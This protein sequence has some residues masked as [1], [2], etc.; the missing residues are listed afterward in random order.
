MTCQVALLDGI[1][2]ASAIFLLVI[3]LIFEASGFGTFIAGQPGALLLVVI[4]ISMFWA[5]WSISG[6]RSF[7]CAT[8]SALNMFD[9]ASTL[10][11][12]NFEINPAVR[13]IGP[14]LFLVSKISCSIVIVLYAKFHHAPKRGG[15]ILSLLLA[16]IVGW[17]LSQHTLA[18]LGLSNV[19][20]GLFFGTLLSFVAASIV[21]LMLFLGEKSH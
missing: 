12:W 20:L 13:S 3:G 5:G 1:I 14:T 2:F 18:Y 11:F 19:T 6:A 15:I 7:S 17:N 10:A 9:A 4:G 16:A 21:V 8:A